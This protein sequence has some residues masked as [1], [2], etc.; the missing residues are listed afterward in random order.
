MP[1]VVEADRQAADQRQ[2]CADAVRAEAR[3]RLDIVLT[4]A[5]T[6]PFYQ[7][8][9]WWDR[10]ADPEL[11][12]L[13]DLTGLPILE[14]DELRHHTARLAAST[15]DPGQLDLTFTSGTNGAPSHILRPR[16]V[17]SDQ[18]ACEAR[19]YSG[20]GLPRV[21]DLTAV[22]PW[23]GSGRVNAAL[24][25]LRVGYHEL[26]ARDVLR[27]LEHRLGAGDLLLSSP[28]VLALLRDRVRDWNDV[29]VLASSFEVSHSWPTDG[30]S[31]PTAEMYC[32][33]E[34]ATP[35]A[36][37]Y[38][39]C[40]G[41]HVNADFVHV[42]V[43]GPDEAPRP[44]G[45]A[46][47]IVVTDLVN[48]AMPILRYRIGDAGTLQEPGACSCGRALPLLR[49]HGRLVTTVR[50]ENG[51]VP[52]KALRSLLGPGMLEQRTTTEFVFHGTVEPGRYETAAEGF[53]RLLGPV[54]ISTGPEAHQDLAPWD[55]AVLLTAPR[56][57][58]ERHFA[59]PAPTRWA[60]LRQDSSPPA[61]SSVRTARDTARR[62]LRERYAA[63]G[64]I[65]DVPIVD[66]SRSMYPL[67]EK[68]TRVR[69]RWGRP[70]GAGLRG[71]V[72]LLQLP[73][74]LL[75]AHRV[76]DVRTT[77]DG[78]TE[79]LQFADNYDPHNPF[80]YFW[81][82]ID[83][84]LGTV[85]G[86]RTAHGRTVDLGTR[87]ARLAGRLVAAADRAVTGAG[88]PDRFAVLPLLLV[89]KAVFR[90]SSR[91]LQKTSRGTTP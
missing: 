53:A 55:G 71:R 76:A 15:A 6:A 46:G 40:A 51:P 52:A 11:R 91:L 24:R 89:Q 48:T 39:G 33:A 37:S 2:W 82:P 20:L 4:A 50:G 72:V 77:P 63:E 74:D 38:P 7:R 22:T 5:E 70:H 25:D 28:D 41:M 9:P 62:V 85:I 73:Q 78:R 21:F 27:R 64:R 81:V 75:A 26:G 87:P 10:L 90:I 34:V 84:V 32:A 14:R 45:R 12:D 83:D 31:P 86:L 54:S 13:P 3:R 57:P 67:F 88:R 42:E 66:T 23:P 47:A 44:Y 30:T 69:V 18:G 35:I 56:H 49:V 17:P 59:G 19:W 61:A 80:C 60:Y 68:G 8:E 29:R 65:T 36:F 1:R 58:V 16:D 43:V 79:I